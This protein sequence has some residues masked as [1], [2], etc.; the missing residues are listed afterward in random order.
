MSRENPTPTEEAALSLAAI[1]GPLSALLHPTSTTEPFTV[2]IPHRL[3]V[4]AAE[5]LEQWDDVILQ[6]QGVERDRFEHSLP[7]AGPDITVAERLAVALHL[8]M[9]FPSG[10]FDP[11]EEGALPITFQPFHAQELKDALLHFRLQIEAPLEPPP[12]PRWKR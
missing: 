3:G 5:A 8:A 6:T 7:H 10:T 1:A 4:G 12:K 11:N 2:E 9:D